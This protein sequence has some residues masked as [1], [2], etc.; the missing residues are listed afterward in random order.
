MPNIR[1][2]TNRE[3]L[4]PN[5]QAAEILGRAVARTSASREEGARLIE[6]RARAV[7][8]RG[9]VTAGIGEDEARVARAE[10]GLLAMEDRLDAELRADVT[11][12]LK[13]VGRTATIAYEKF[14][15]QPELSRGAAEGARLANALTKQW[16]DLAKSSDPNDTTIAEK[17]YASTLEPELERFAE[18]FGTEAGQKWA[19][20]YTASLRQHLFDKA[21]ADMASRAGDAAILN[22]DRLG[23]EL[24]SL[25][26][27]DPTAA[28]FTLSQVG[29]AVDVIVASHPNIGAQAASRIARDATKRIEGEIAKSAIRG[30][31]DKNPL[32]G[33][34][35][36]LSK[37]YDAYLTGEEKAIL[38][39]Y[40][41]T[42]ARMVR[43]EKKAAEVEERR[44]QKEAANKVANELLQ[45]TLTSDGSLVIPK[46]FLR[47]VVTKLATMPG[48]DPDLPKSMVAFARAVTNDNEQNVKR[49]TDPAEYQELSRLFERDELTVARVNQA[50]I[51]GRLSQQDHTRWHQFANDAVT[52]PKFR[53][54]HAELTKVLEG[55]RGFITRSSVMAPNASPIGDNLYKQ[56][57]VW[58][59]NYLREMRGKE[60]LQKTLLAIDQAY[61]Q[62]QP[63]PAEISKGMDEILREG[64]TF[65]RRVTPIT[66]GQEIRTPPVS[67][68]GTEGV[69]MRLPGVPSPGV[70]WKPGMSM[71]ELAKKIGGQ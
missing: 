61:I 55:R 62:F 9:S 27:D 28:D 5:N 36:V 16:N 2:Y 35:M 42:R 20:Q 6:S 26:Y 34:D 7:S 51:E 19:R 48:V 57:Q 11:A 59:E 49:V 56:Y 47:N 66:P 64:I 63:T 40:S 14:V 24:S 69:R 70:Q 1:E 10:G 71:D 18:G 8:Q 21:T 67:G 29:P 15:E 41:E 22:V 50:Y 4:R 31:T 52:N 53:Q 45:T 25:A 23:N 65:T 33:A 58:A 46:D 3:E 54:E 37:K 30:A 38:L 13:T 17:F 32:A 43:D 68:P 39:A 60:P 12:G 44:I